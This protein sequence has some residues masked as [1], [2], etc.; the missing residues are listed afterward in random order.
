VARLSTAAQKNLYVSTPGFDSGTLT[1]AGQQ[2]VSAF[3]STFGH[4][5]APQAIFGYEAMSAVLA[6]LKQAGAD[7]GSR[8]AVVADFLALHNRQSALGTYS[9]TS[10]DISLAPFVFGRPHG[11][12]LGLVAPS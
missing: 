8:S 9:I 6:V 2:F 10:G 7:A 1:P 5:P 3:R 11:G 12:R 4:A